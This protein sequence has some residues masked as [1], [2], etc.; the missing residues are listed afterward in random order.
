MTDVRK[1][2]EP[3]RDLHERIR[4]AVI[5][6]CERETS[7]EL[8]KVVK[9]EEGDTIFAVDRV[10]EELLVDFFEREVAHATPLVLIAEGLEGGQVILPHGATESDAVWRIIVD[11]IDGTRGLMYQKR[12]AWI[13]TGVAPNRGPDTDLTDI[14][15]AVQ[16]EI[17]LNKQHLS[18]VLWAVKGGGACAERFNRLTGKQSPLRLQPSNAENILQGY[19]QITRFFP[20]AR[21]VLAA[22]DDEIVFAALGPVQPGKTHCFEDQYIS[23]GGQLYELM[24]GH[25][26]YVADLRSLMAPVLA[27]RGM[28]AALCC[29]PYDLCTEL[30]ARELGVVVTGADGGPLRARL[31]V[32]PDVSWAGYANQKIRSSIEPLLQAALSRR[33]LMPGVSKA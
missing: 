9:E 20:G 7:A 13:L 29:H 25:D 28:P 26:R 21:D 15:L 17:P 4:A 23:S 3:I 11:P 6:A 1:L 27:E 2:L 30:I 22:I 10:S 12:S 31:A 19:A 18:D 32:E 24:A 33:G 14:E 8:A 5:A 16:T